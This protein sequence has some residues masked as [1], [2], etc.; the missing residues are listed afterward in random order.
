M[1]KER[2]LP[3][4]AITIIL[5][6]LVLVGIYLTSLYSYLLFHGIAEIFGIIVAC[7]IFIVAWNSRRFLDNNYLLLLGIAYLFV[8]I[9]DLIHTLSYKGMYI[10]HG[11]SANLP[12]QLWIAARYLE[13]VSLLIAPLF[14]RRRLRVK[15]VFAA[16]AL[17]TSLALGSI[18]YL[19]VFPVCFVDGV[20]LTPFKKISEYVICLILLASLVPLF[21]KREEFDRGVFM[22]IAASIVLT[23]G[24]ELSFTYYVHAYGLS[25]LI[26]HYLKIISF[27]LL[28]KALIETGLRNPYNLLFRDL[29]K[30]E[31]ELRHSEKRFRQA[32]E[33]ANTGM[34]LVSPE[35]RYLMVNDVLCRML[36][37]SREEL[38]SMA[39]QDTVHPDD[40][41]VCS[42]F[43]SRALAGEIE[44][45]SFEARHLDRDAQVVWTHVA[46]SLVRDERGEPVYFITQVSDVTDRRRAEMALKK[47]HDELEVRVEER[48]GELV[49]AQND[50]RDALG[51][52]ERLKD[53]LEMENIYLQEEIKLNHNFEEIIGR[54]EVMKRV[55]G[56][57]EQVAS[58]DATVLI[59][60]ETGTG[61][62]LFAR[63][64]HSLSPRNDRPLVKVN[65]AA[66]QQTLI[67]SELFGH[68]KGAFTGA[69]AQRVG[70]FELANNGTIFLDEI[71][72]LSLELQSKLLRVIQEGELERLGGS[73]TIKVDVRLIAATNRDL[74]KEVEAGSF[75]EDLFYRLHVFPVVIPPLRERSKD[76]SLLVRHFSQKYSTALG[77]TIDNIPQKVMEA[78]EAY[79][80]SG[81]VRELEN[82]IERA[83]ILA[84]G[85][86]LELD[87]FLD[88]FGEAGPR[89]VSLETLD[90][91]QRSHIIR[92]LEETN[93]KVEGKRGAAVLLGINP[94]TLRSRMRKLGIK[95]GLGMG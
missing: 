74:E 63:A 28:Y 17:V 87:D 68:E 90:E 92:T 18:F 27:Y 21:K 86:V 51:Q 39:V 43:A 8:G 55:L 88:I 19:D 89:D 95:R 53:R 67:E 59:M 5:G 80:W 93:W 48:T 33:N 30:R 16:Y 49:Q 2:V 13:S 64:I 75:R 52:V 71:G 34:T 73:R 65:C 58:T 72:D 36:G 6:I 7:G 38:E 12:T 10:F 32:F 22:M 76:I 56:R 35:G 91:V 69:F 54:S 37:Y 82:V 94:S 31:E 77:K 3:T 57:V 24:S 1:E 83:V 15:L 23:I 14:F 25:N 11:S 9:I 47:A 81:N 29:A 61:K 78:L 50:L 45:S 60:G 85:S 84:R 41:H 66:L 70:R 20:G 44:S 62:E 4:H 26:G 79:Q 40:E 42:S 46:S